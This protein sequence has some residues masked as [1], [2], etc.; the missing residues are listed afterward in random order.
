[1]MKKLL[2]SLSRRNDWLVFLVTVILVTK[3]ILLCSKIPASDFTFHWMRIIF[4]ICMAL[5]SVIPVFLLA[6]FV[7]TLAVKL[8]LKYVFE[9]EFNAPTI[10]RVCE[11]VH[12]IPASNKKAADK[13]HKCLSPRPRLSLGLR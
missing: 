2:I 13:K 4:L 5:Y 1:M 10:E 11:G 6:E 12:F 7:A 9:Y 3:V 8:I